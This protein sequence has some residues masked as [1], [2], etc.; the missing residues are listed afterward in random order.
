MRFN[1][2]CI[3]AL[4]V[5]AG[6]MTAVPTRVAFAQEASAVDIAQARELLNRGLALRSKGDPRGAISDLKAAYG[7]A[8]TPI[9]GLEL[10]RTYMDLGQL[11]E[12]R[13]TF[14]SIA[15]LATR[16]EETSRSKAARTESASLAEQ[17]RT[18]IPSLVV[19]VTGVAL[20]SVAVTIDGA[21]VPGEALAAPRLVDPGVHAVA[22][23]STTGGAADTTVELK[24][25]ESREVELKIVFTGGTP[26]SA[27]SPRPDRTVAEPP[28]ATQALDAATPT[29]RP[30]L[31]GWLLVGGSAV[32][33][34]AGLTLMGVEIGKANDA[35]TAHD[36][37]RY[38][39][40]KTGW[41]VGL[42]GSVAGAVGLAA[43]G[44]VVLAT[45]RAPESGQ[46]TQAHVWLSAGLDDVRVEGTW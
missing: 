45:R 27:E 36:R 19:K 5:T 17:L 18:R 1:R 32:V 15:R 31:G 14:L 26:P 37:S 29:Q 11:V 25:G 7:L 20:D 12:A 28:L 35:V 41:T 23:R 22:A 21:A 4:C 6:A 9:P 39:S 38:D 30:S 42:I 46:A 3:A 44:V 33:G 43:G 16:P 10:G 2:I 13:E 24:E 8:R 34:I 40:A